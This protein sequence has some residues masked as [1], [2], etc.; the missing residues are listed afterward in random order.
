MQEKISGKA[1]EAVE[2]IP[3]R[4]QLQETLS[5]YAAHPNYAVGAM[6]AAGG[7]YDYYNIG[8][9]TSLTTGVGAGALMLG[10]G[11]LVDRD[12]QAA[13]LLGSATSG[14]LTVGM[15]PRYMKVN[16]MMPVGGAALLGAAGLAYNGWQLWR[17]WDPRS[18]KK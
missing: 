7:M 14:A 6:L 15:L 3:D 12:P 8:N 17:W 4:R 11:L 1:H 13:F 10:S 18:G 9:M 5:P 2:K 16:Q